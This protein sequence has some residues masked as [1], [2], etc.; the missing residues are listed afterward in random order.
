[1]QCRHHKLSHIAI[2]VG[3]KFC[4]TWRCRF[5]RAAYVWCMV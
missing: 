1:M 5:S 2:S 4:N 3:W